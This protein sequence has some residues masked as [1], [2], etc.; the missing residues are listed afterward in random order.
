MSKVITLTNQQSLI[1]HLEKM[2]A[3]AGLEPAT[4]AL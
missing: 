2:V 1:L 3:M 4:P